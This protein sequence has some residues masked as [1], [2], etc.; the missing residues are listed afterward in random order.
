MVNRGTLYGTKNVNSNK[1]A[2]NEK[3]LYKNRFLN[4]GYYTTKQATLNKFINKFR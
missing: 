2:D 1:T 4:S 3:T